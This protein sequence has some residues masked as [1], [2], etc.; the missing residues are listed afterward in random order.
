MM[1]KILLVEDSKEIKQLV[2]VALSNN[3]ANLDW[4]KTIE[5]A[6]SFLDKNDYTLVLLD[7]E[8][9]DGSGFTLCSEIQNSSADTAIF[10]LTAHGELSEKVMGFSAGADDYITKPFEPLELQARVAA[11]IKKIELSQANA[12]RLEWETIHINKSSQE[13][14]IKDEEGEM[15]SVELTS[16]EFKLL[17]YLANRVGQVVER[18][19]M[20]DEI[21]GEDVHVYARSV[22]THISKLRKKLENQSETI[23]SVHGVGYKF[24]P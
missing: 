14:L 7:I 4:A 21:W 2:D 12:D 23:E 3:I 19:K 17:M 24:K 5:E 10:F 6:R 18:E 9:P 1:K 15:K 16:L 20:L 13:V 22:D 11:K 8:L